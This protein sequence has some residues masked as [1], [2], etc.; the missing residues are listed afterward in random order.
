MVFFTV[1]ELIERVRMKQVQVVRS[2]SEL[3]CTAYDSMGSNAQQR[4]LYD[5]VNVELYQFNTA[6]NCTAVV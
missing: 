2:G 3:Y 6:L 1:R 4:K 5:F